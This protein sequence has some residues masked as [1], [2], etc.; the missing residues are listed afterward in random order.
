[1]TIGSTE[2]VAFAAFQEIPEEYRKVGELLAK[3]GQ[4]AARVHAVLMEKAKEEGMSVTWDRQRVADK[5]TKP[6]LG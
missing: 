1:M 6:I 3:T 2:Q 4:G 5:I